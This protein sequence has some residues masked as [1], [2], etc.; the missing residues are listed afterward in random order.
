MKKAD[1]KTLIERIESGEPRTPEGVRRLNATATATAVQVLSIMLEDMDKT[2]T[3]Y[4]KFVK[5]LGGDPAAVYRDGQEHAEVNLKPGN[6]V[7]GAQPA[8]ERMGY[9]D[10]GTGSV[11]HFFVAG[12]VAFAS[13]F[14][15]ITDKTGTIV[16]VKETN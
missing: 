16:S 7:L 1:L 10:F 2:E 5:T 8:A 4:E 15:I 6:K 12:W 11:A 3:E 14:D 9:T 13:R